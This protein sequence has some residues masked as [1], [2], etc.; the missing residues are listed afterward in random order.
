MTR[1]TVARF[2]GV[3]LGNEYAA[4]LGKLY[5]DAPKAVLAAIAVSFGT[6]GGDRLDEARAV[7]L[8]EWQA[9][10][11][12]GIV[13]QKPPT[14]NVTAPVTRA[15]YERDAMHDIEENAIPEVGRDPVHESPSERPAPENDR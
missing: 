2:N 13:P 3:K 4:E 14:P 1:A 9:L 5:N 6:C 7:V 12:A 15:E 11:L 8:K 10:Y